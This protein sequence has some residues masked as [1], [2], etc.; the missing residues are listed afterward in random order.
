MKSSCAAHSCTTRSNETRPGVEGVALLS[1]MRARRPHPVRATTTGQSVL[2]CRSAE[3]ARPGR[4]PW[5]RGRSQHSHDTARPSAVRGSAASGAQYGA[6]TRDST[7]ATTRRQVPADGSGLRAGEVRRRHGNSRARAWRSSLV[8]GRRSPRSRGAAKASDDEAWSPSQA[9]GGPP[10]LPLV[11]AEA[12]LDSRRD[13]WTTVLEFDDEESPRFRMEGRWGRSRPRDRPADLDFGCDLPTVPVRGATGRERGHPCVL[14]ARAGAGDLRGRAHRPSPR[15]AR[16][17]PRAVRLAESNV[18]S[19]IRPF[20]TRTPSLVSGP[21]RRPSSLCV[22]PT[23]VR[24]P[25]TASP[26]T[27][28]YGSGGCTF[29]VVHAPAYHARIRGSAFR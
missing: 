13:R 29:R 18:R 15:V 5:L 16:P 17:S 24:T 6:S 22:Q 25:L 19:S 11:P 20:S 1:G 2:G 12:P 8:R 14:Q 26:T 23:S 21:T 4:E 10:R 27:S 7:M 28:Q 9:L 3:P